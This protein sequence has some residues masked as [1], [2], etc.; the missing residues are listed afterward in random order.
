[1]PHKSANGVHRFQE[2]P[3]F[4]KIEVSEQNPQN[5]SPTLFCWEQASTMM[6]HIY[7]YIHKYLH[8]MEWYEYNFIQG[9]V[10]SDNATFSDLL[11]V[12]LAP[13]FGHAAASD[14][15]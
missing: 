5:P 15:P 3:F 12:A 11:V 2:N 6:F 10:I 13:P 4:S 9:W 8:R 1:M 7:I 14:N